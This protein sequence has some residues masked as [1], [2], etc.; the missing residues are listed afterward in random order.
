MLSDLRESGQIEQDADLVIFIYRDEYYNPETTDARAR[1]S[2][3]SPSTATAALGDV[4]LTFQ[5]EYPQ[6]PRRSSARHERRSAERP[7][8]SASATARGFVVDEATNAARSLPLPR[9]GASQRHARAQ[10]ERA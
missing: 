10:P 8:R 4:P 2:S 1:P 5:N 6:L 7:A 9:R 3:S